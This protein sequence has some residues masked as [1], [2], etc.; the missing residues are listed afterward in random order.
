MV[1]HP[2]QLR[3]GLVFFVGEA[4]Y[5]GYD[6]LRN[7]LHPAIDEHSAGTGQG[8][9]S[10]F[11]VNADVGNHRHRSDTPR[12]VGQVD[13]YVLSFAGRVDGADHVTNVRLLVD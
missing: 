12:Q 7:V 9:H 5:L 1:V 2:R 10:E 13:H 11:A 4:R 6:G 3:H 8:D